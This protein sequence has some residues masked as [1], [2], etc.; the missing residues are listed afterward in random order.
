MIIVMKADTQPDSPERAQPTGVV[1][2]EPIEEFTY[3]ES[4]SG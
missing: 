4:A 2:A 3:V 1:P